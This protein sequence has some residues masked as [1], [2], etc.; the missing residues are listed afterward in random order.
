MI[1]LLYIVKS[2][3]T[4]ATWR[5]VLIMSESIL[6]SAGTMTQIAG[7]LKPF[8]C[9]HQIRLMERLNLF[10]LYTP[11]LVKSLNGVMTKVRIY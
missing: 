4:V 7:I 8:H 9:T 3:L 6:I 10:V 11:I 1:T 2:N 5:P